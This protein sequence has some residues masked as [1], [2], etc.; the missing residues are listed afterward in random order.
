MLLFQQEIKAFESAL[1][2]MLEDC[3]GQFVVIQGSEVFKVLPTYEA[4]IEWGYDRFGLDRF[5]VKQISAEEPVAH[6]SR[7]LG[8]CGP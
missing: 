2:K 5:F 4:A 8:T 3:D 6:F 7:D 1:P